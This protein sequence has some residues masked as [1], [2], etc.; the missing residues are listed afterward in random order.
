MSDSSTLNNNLAPMR[1]ISMVIVIA[2]IFGIFIIQLFNYQVIQGQEWIDLAEEN[3]IS[4]YSIPTLRGVIFDQNGIVLARNV[5]SYNAVVLPAN[6][7]DDPGEIQE[8]FRELSNTL[9]MPVNLGEIS[10]ET[11]Y[12]PCRSEHGIAQIV[13]Y[14]QTSTPYTPVKVKCNID[15]ITAMILKERSVDWSGVD[16]E[17]EPIR[18]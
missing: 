2:V 3:R 11:P 1:I 4:E 8:I 6:L 7:P 16:I 13:N 12:V 14:G 9:N 10:P 18:D 5:A 17:I 15:E